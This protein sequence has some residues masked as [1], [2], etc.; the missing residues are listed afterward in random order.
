MTFSISARV[1][2]TL[3]CI[4]L[5][6]LCFDFKSSSFSTKRFTNSYIDRSPSTSVSESENA[7]HL[8][9]LLLLFT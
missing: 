8:M 9:L 5:T 4:F 3:F 1:R 7:I 6:S 2:R